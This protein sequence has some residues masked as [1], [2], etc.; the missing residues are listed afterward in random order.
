MTLEEALESVS[1]GG[2]IS[3]TIWTE[4]PQDA[5]IAPEPGVEYQV[6]VIITKTGED[7]HTMEARVLA[8]RQKGAPDA[9]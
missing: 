8:Q 5:G 4:H 3:Q 7:T 9:R 6:K 2:H 1:I